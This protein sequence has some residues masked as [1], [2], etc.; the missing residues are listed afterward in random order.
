VRRAAID[1]IAHPAALR[2]LLL[3]L[4]KEYDEQSIAVQ[5]DILKNE[6]LSMGIAHSINDPSFASTSTENNK[7]S[8]QSLYIEYY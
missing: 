2:P 8:N 5:Q 4:P 6:L 1:G 7:M 3:I